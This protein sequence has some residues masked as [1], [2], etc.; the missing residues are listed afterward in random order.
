MV[1][2]DAAPASAE[3]DGV[4]YTLVR[5][6]TGE[7]YLYVRGEARTTNAEGQP[8]SDGEKYE[9]ANLLVRLRLND[10]RLTQEEILALPRTHYQTLTSLAIHLDNEEASIARD[11]LSIH[12]QQFPAFRFP[13]ETSSDS[14]PPGPEDSSDS[15]QESDAEPKSK[16]R[17]K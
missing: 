7:D 3:M 11:F 5:Q 15:E 12:L 1:E 14:P 6:T 17:R 9:Q 8:D 4:V 2:L 13:S 16:P 10:Q